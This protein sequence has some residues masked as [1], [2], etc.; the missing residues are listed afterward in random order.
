MTGETIDQSNERAALWLGDDQQVGSICEPRLIV[1]ERG[2]QA[3]NHRE[4]KLIYF[5]KLNPLN[6]NTILIQ[7]I[8]DILIE[9]C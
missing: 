4:T 3:A 9:L 8:A 1:T 2:R 5:V 6:K 7:V